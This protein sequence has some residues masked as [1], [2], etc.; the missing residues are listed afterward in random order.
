MLRYYAGQHYFTHHDFFD[1]KLYK[2]AEYVF[3][4]YAVQCSAVQCSAV[5]C[6]AV[7]CSAVQ[8]RQLRI[9]SMRR[10]L[11]LLVLTLATHA[12]T[13][14]WGTPARNHCGTH[15]HGSLTLSHGFSGTDAFVAVIGRGIP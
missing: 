6:S 15:A 2:D 3:A 12:R 10:R 11:H 14:A 4:F 9:A 13:P 5:Q 1:P 7:Q 8:C